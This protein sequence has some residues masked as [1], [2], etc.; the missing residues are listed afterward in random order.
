MAA[1]NDAGTVISALVITASNRAAAGV[2]PDRSGPVLADLLGTA[3]CAVDGPV[4]VPDGEPV[5]AALRSAVADGSARLMKAPAWTRR[6][7]AGIPA[8][9]CQRR[10]MEHMTTWLATNRK[11]VDLTRRRDGATARSNQTFLKRT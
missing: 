6:A 7:P 9:V 11:M 3:G 4:V 10:I 2:Y 8:G 1:V 5:E